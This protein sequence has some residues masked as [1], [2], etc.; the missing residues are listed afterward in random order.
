MKKQELIIKNIDPEIRN[1]V[2][3]IN[4]FKGI[5]TIFSCS[6]HS[7]GES[8]Y[9]TFKGNSQ[10]SLNNLLICLPKEWNIRGFRENQPY[11]K[12]IWINAELMPKYGL[13]YS[14]R[15]QGSPFYVQRELIREIERRIITKSKKEER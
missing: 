7:L 4:Q 14:I 3:L 11:S 10:K 5:E 1:L 2:Y 8:G 6:G 15:F 9:I 12:D 13:V